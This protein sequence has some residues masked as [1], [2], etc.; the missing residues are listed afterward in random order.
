M[1]PTASTN[2]LN[3]VLFLIAAMIS[4]A[5]LLAVPSPVS[6]RGKKLVEGESVN[7]NT[8]GFKEFV[9]LSGV[10]KATAKRILEYREA[11]GSFSSI[12]DLTNIRGIGKKTVAKLRP[13]LRLEGET[14]IRKP[15]KKD[16]TKG[17]GE[18]MD[19]SEAPGDDLPP[20]AP[21]DE[22]TGKDDV[23]VL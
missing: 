3:R 1:M 7:I 11:N 19:E 10:G 9:K 17:A 20:E 18:G 22:S 21:K 23:E 12:D 4:L 16:G 5:A 2:S 14:I 15:P 8:A 13:F 6:A